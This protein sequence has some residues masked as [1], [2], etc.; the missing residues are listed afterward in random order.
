MEETDARQTAELQN[1]DV[2]IIINDYPRL[3]QAVAAE[4]L[5]QKPA[6]M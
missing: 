2:N 4:C 3:P 1:Y 6:I 5:P